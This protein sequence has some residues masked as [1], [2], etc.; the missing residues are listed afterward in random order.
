M[1]VV[2]SLMMIIMMV[3]PHYTRSATPYKYH[4][5]VQSNCHYGIEP[6]KQTGANSL[7][8]RNDDDDT[9]ARTR[10]SKSL[11]L[12]LLLPI[13]ILNQFN[14]SPDKQ[15]AGLDLDPN[16]LTRIL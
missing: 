11:L 9:S 3:M 12:L 5:Q 6:R 4:N 15:M 13:H 10:A 8:T 16:V 7:Q 2:D 1:L 14:L